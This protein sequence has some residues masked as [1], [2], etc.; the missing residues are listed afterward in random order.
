MFSEN[1]CV[2]WIPLFYKTCKGF[3]R[4]N[5]KLFEYYHWDRQVG[6]LSV[7]SY[8]SEL[9]S[10]ELQDLEI[11]KS[12]RQDLEFSKSCRHDHLVG[13]IWNFLNLA[14]KIY[15]YFKFCRQDLDFSK[16]CWQDLEYSKF[17]M[18][19]FEF[20]KSCRARV[21]LVIFK[22]FIAISNCV[23]AEL[24]ASDDEWSIKIFNCSQ[25]FTFARFAR[26][27]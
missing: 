14:C 22:I 13:K 7:V 18:Q 21:N 3:I 16:S 26:K 19:D 4:F 9:A 20:S 15:E 23:R 2:R 1:C 5:F 10:G 6:E 24:R 12:C 8:C 27:I 25:N 17:C 11:S